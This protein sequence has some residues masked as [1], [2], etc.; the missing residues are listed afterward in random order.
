MKQMICQVCSYLLKAEDVSLGNCSM[1]G[2]PDSY[3]RLV[4]ERL[5]TEPD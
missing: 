4:P 5:A 3:F 2:A 1:C